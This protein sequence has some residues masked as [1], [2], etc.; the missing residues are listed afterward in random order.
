MGEVS[1][2]V[3]TEHP[4]LRQPTPWIKPRIDFESLIRITTAQL[5]AG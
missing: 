5:T 2:N 4:D 3:D 1:G